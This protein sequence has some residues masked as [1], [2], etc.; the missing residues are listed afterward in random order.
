MKF[1]TFRGKKALQC[2]LKNF[3]RFMGFCLRSL[4]LRILL[5]GF[6]ARFLE[7]FAVSSFG[8]SSSGM[9]TEI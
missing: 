2:F 3:S 9:I 1:A 7:I 8:L 5:L 4:W 6:A